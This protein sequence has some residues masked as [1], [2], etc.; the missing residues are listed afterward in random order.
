MAADGN[1]W[2]NPAKGRTNTA[3]A[4]EPATAKAGKSAKAQAKES[5]AP[6][7]QAVLRELER[8]GSK[9]VCDIEELQAI[10]GAE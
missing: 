8:N 6:D 1:A 10:A 2:K 3:K 5:V 7:V 9:I 4:G